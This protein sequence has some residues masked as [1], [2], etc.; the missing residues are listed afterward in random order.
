MNRKLA[1]KLFGSALAFAALAFAGSAAQAQAGNPASNG[2]AVHIALSSTVQNACS[3]ATSTTAVTLG[4]VSVTQYNGTIAN[5]NETCN[6]LAGGYTVKL[7]ST[8]AGTGT[9]FYL[10]GAN[11][12]NTTHNPL[13]LDL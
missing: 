9:A 7:T 5:L 4:D 1:R 13:H 2:N 8:N 10:A 6:D 3:I 11:T 12:N